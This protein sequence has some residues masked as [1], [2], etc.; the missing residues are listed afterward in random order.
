MLGVGLVVA[1]AGQLG[2]AQSPAPEQRRTWHDY[3]G[4][5]DNARYM[6]LNQITKDNVGKLEVAWTYPTQDNVAY[7]FNPVVVDNMMYVLARN[8]SLVAI[9]ATSGK[10]IWVREN[11]ADLSPRGLNYWESKDRSDRRLLFQMDNYLQA[12]DA[13]TGKTILTF[14]N[15]GAVNLRE[16][17][18]RDASKVARIES[19]NPGKV[20]ENL[21]VLGSATGEAYLSVPGD[22][23][24][25]DVVTGKLAWQFHTIPHPG[26]FGYETW[27]KDAYKYIGGVNTWGELTL[28]EKRGIVFCPLGSPTYDYYGA[29]R[30]GANLFGTSLVA[31]DAR[32]GKR[33]WHFQLV[34][35]DL[36]DYD[37]TAAPQ[38]TTIKKGGQSVDVVALAGKTGFLYVF[39]RVT[40]EPIWPIE[41][42]P[43]PQTDVP[44]EQ[45]WPTQP[46]PTNPPPFAKQT[47]TVADL[48][49]YILTTEQRAEWA[50]RLSK[51]RNLGMFTPPAVGIDTVAIPGAQG[52][53]NWGVTAANPTNGSVY[54]L[55]INVPSIYN[56]TLQQPGQGGGGRGGAA[57]AAAV[58]MAAVQQGSVIYEQRCAGCHGANRAGTAQFP[59]LVGITGRLT[60]DAI[61]ETISGGRPAMPP[62]SDIGEAQMAMLI[63]FL[64]TSVGPNGR[65]FAVNTNVVTPGAPPAAAAGG[66]G[67]GR[68]GGPAPVLG[69]P[70]VGSG[71][72]PGVD[73][74]LPLGG[75]G[76]VGPAYPDGLDAPDS[77]YY[78][79][80]GMN[81]TLVR[82]PY[83]TL[84]AYDLNTGTIKW[85]VPAGGDQPQAIA[86]GGFD[87]GFPSARGG[88]ITTSTGLL[89]NAGSDGKLRAYDVETGKVLWTG[90]LPAGSRGVP[91]MYE[92]NGRQYLVINATQGAPGGGG[93]R[94]AAAANAPPA[95]PKAYVAF[96]LPR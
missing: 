42:R 27:P 34:H 22:I 5:P 20:F 89:F 74:S 30:H 18:G 25:F 11:M 95:P 79:G 53:A 62:M 69:G 49:P 75:G 55:S 46:F 31:L 86:Q 94:G 66:G 73:K 28:D 1:V 35:H 21:I 93:G 82:P 64:G 10:E 83:S 43:V 36:W 87:T 29:D 32:T 41:E 45:T 96:A 52:G 63:T 7:V 44:G 8:N 16:G 91:T 6:T 58:D 17:L 33:L 71:S 51:A 76:M 19:K 80:Y 78:T 88:I 50:T 40:G 60:G 57:P 85:Q 13:R 65:G 2:H 68:A 47:L 67:R 38:L 15:Q 54:V 61:R 92:L 48:N 24:A 59:S 12:L 70:V 23:R 3:G 90:Q 37:P 81:G 9:D 4:G 26:E 39:N 14:G 56:L 77:R 72:A 84:T